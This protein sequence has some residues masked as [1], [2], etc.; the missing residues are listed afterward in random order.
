LTVRSQ[1]GLVYLGLDGL[2]VYACSP[3]LWLAVPG[4]ALLFRRRDLRPEAALIT[5]CVVLYLSFNACYGET[6][7]FWGGGRSLGPRHLVPVLGLLALPLCRGARALPWIFFPLLAVSAFYMLIGTA[8]EPR[9]PYVFENP[10]RDMYVP[11]FLDGW[12]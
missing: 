9:V 11:R 8:I 4:L 7:I 5:L 2:R 3:V 1:R 12:F 10:Y 6:V